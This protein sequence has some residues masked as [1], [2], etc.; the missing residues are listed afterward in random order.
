MNIYVTN[1]SILFFKLKP[2]FE[3]FSYD[4]GSIYN[5]DY[6]DIK[7][8][9][10]YKTFSPASL[11]LFLYE[12]YEPIMNNNDKIVGYKMYYALIRNK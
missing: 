4:D 3:M 8:I 11:M 12:S 10:D 9:I 5:F 6:L 1:K 2:K 7:R